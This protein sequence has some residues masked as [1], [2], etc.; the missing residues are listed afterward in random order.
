M[1]SHYL[2]IFTV[3]IKLHINLNRVCNRF[4]L[5]RAKEQMNNCS[6]NIQECF[7]WPKRD[8]AS[9][10]WGVQSPTANV[11]VCCLNQADENPF[12]P[13]FSHPN[14]A[15]SGFLPPADSDLTNF[16][17]RLF[18]NRSAL[19]LQHCA[20]LSSPS[21]YT[22]STLNSSINLAFIIQK[23]EDHNSPVLLG[24]MKLWWFSIHVKGYS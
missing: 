12:H 6:E 17:K 15:V 20:C 8:R 24:H 23:V 16:R 11:C 14:Y 13:N 1:E 18:L 5:D 9:E 4:K 10:E 3:S 19:A 7:Y 2:K 21:L 22:C